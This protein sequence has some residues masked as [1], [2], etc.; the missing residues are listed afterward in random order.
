MRRSSFAS[1]RFN[2]YMALTFNLPMDELNYLPST[3]LKSEYISIYMSVEEN[4][5]IV[6]RAIEAFN[7]GILVML[8]NS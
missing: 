6:R 8:I 4:I 2:I 3:L 5:K 1:N 7:T